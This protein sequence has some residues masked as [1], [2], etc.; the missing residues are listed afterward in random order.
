MQPLSCAKLNSCVITQ[1]EHPLHFHKTISETTRNVIWL[2]MWDSSIY[3]F[4][5]SHKPDAWLLWTM[6]WAERRQIM[7]RPR[8]SRFS[9][10]GARVPFRICSR[11][12]QLHSN[13]LETRRTNPIWPIRGIILKVSSSTST[14]ALRQNCGTDYWSKEAAFVLN[15]F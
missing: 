2:N 4:L 14:R 5:Q 3:L 10:D 13:N 1:Q 8:Y 11:L 12:M 9:E 15:D 7:R 6:I